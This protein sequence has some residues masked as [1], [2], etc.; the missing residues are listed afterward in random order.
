MSTLPLG[1]WKTGIENT[2]DRTALLKTALME[3]VNVDINTDGIIQTRAGITF[4]SSGVK[5]LFHYA[6]V[7][8]GVVD[9]VVSRLSPTGASALFGPVFGQV[10]WCVLNDEP[11]FSTLDGIW[12][13]TPTQVKPIGVDTPGALT[14]TSKG[15]DRY[16]VAATYL[17]ADGEEGGLSGVY[18]VVGD[19]VLIPPPLQGNAKVQL[20]TTRP[21]GETLYAR[22]G[23]D[24][25]PPAETQGLSRLPGGSALRYWRGRLLV[26]RGRT[27]YFSE[28]MRYGLTKTVG[29]FIQL[30]SKITFLEAVESGIYVGLARG[31]VAFLAGNSPDQW[32]FRIASLLPAQAGSSACLPTAQMD[33]NLQLADWVAVWLTPK[34][35]AL[36]STDGRVVYPQADRLTGL[37]LGSGGYLIAED[38]LLALAQ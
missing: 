34:G 33:K 15:E 30:D 27:L 25:G 23:S 16:G 38:R 32:E 22:R 12:R 24:Y 11:V 13:I 1:P 18:F 36:G 9:G 29:G 28:P 35:F 31:V 14:I 20:Y 5:N 8:Y 21:G 3:A 4:L 2:S 17:N 26:A 37:A 19:P 10:A 6:G 7:D